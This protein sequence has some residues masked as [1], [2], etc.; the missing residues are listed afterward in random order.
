MSKD[1]ELVAIVA[2]PPEA[3]YRALIDPVALRQ[4]LAEQVDSDEHRR[5]FRFWGRFTPQGDRPKQ[6]LIATRPN[7]FIQF[8]W[9]LD[10]T[11]TTVT[12]SLK[13]A[14]GGTKVSLR[15]TNLP[16]MDELEEPVGKRDGLQS[17]HTFWPLILSR[18]VEFIERREMTPHCDFSPTRSL[19]IR[20]ETI[21]NAPAA[22]V[23]ESLTNSKEIGKWWGWEAIVE[24]RRGGKIELGSDGTIFEFEPGEMLYYSEPGLETRWNLQ[25]VNDDTYLTFVQSG[26]KA[27]ERDSVAQ[28]EAGWL[29]GIAE[30]KRMHELGNEWSPLVQDV[31]KAD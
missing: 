21:I 28:H 2:A 20:V 22:R 16:T 25:Q 1:L 11:D 10:E 6:R 7:H 30:L 5:I 8:V 9:T 31:S 18:L 27:E 29:A 14:P 26:F 24:P 15:Q 3:V 13:I 4:W 23:F 19:T 17:L 12:I